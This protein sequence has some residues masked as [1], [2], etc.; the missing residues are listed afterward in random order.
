MAQ[1]SIEWTAT[2][3][4]DGARL[5][6][7]TFNPWL[8]CTKISA[9]CDHC[10]AEG[11][12]KRTGG[13]ALWQGERRR[14]TEAYWRQPLK[15][16]REAEA[17]GIR[18]KV[19]CAS[20][21]DVFDNQVPDDWRADLWG[22]IGKTPHLDWLLLT[23]RPQNIGKMLPV[24]NSM[25]PG[26]RPWN[27]FWPDGWPNVWLGTT[28]ESPE[29][30]ARRGQA[31]AMVARDQSVNRIFWSCEPLLANLGEIPRSIMPD[32]IIVGGESGP[33]ARPMQDDW[34]RQILAQC[35]ATKV[36]FFM[37]QMGGTRKP[38]RPI[39]DD[40]MVMEFPDAV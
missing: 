12:A 7:Y 8:G 28:V 21:A 19:F 13:A 6:G 30:M 24:T 35:K 4:P 40:L 10:Y 22:L 37:K 3:L 16:N 23:K 29:E 36:P 32:W 15:W 18:R 39:P 14:T 17:S 1:T 27:A 9:A 26:Y 11:W 25:K 33:N 20:L 34:A 5:P 31:L 38:F 2:L